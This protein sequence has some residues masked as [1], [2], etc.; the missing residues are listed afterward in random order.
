MLRRCY[1]NTDISIRAQS[2]KN[3]CSVHP[4][5]HNFQV[6]AD[7]Y[8]YHYRKEFELDKDILTK[9]NKVYSPNT[10]CFV[11]REVNQL[12]VKKDVLRGELPV[13]VSRKRNK[14]QAQISKGSIR[15]HLTS[16]NTPEEAFQVY[17]ITKESYIKEI[18]DKYRGKISDQTYQA[19]YNYKVEI[20]D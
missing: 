12:F 1:D 7:W 15:T 2:Y 16:F 19:M 14:F 5:W 9:G 11:P 17:K 13:G 20:T 3:C 18:A 10:C 6:F 8:N 4:D